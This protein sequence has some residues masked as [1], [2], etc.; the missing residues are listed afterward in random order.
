MVLGILKKND[1]ALAA[2]DL[3]VA[4]V[5]AARHP[6]F[7]ST[8]GVPDTMDGRFE[9]IALHVSL[10]MNMLAGEKAGNALSQALFDTMFQN[11]DQA[12]REM[13]VGDLSVPRHMK[14]MMTA[15]NG[16]VH[17]YAAAVRAGTKEG[18]AEALRRN[19]FGTVPDI[20]SE[21]VNSLAVYACA[22]SD[23]LAGAGP[24]SF[25]QGNAAFPAPALPSK[26]AG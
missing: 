7:Y 18:W 14:R 12:L 20:A 5:Q 24:M 10:I 11:M 8:Y 1:T 15:F 6:V 13:G 22:A 17:V 3:Y 16:R 23:A 26:Q 2:F 25:F 19:V 9:M 4:A 21:N